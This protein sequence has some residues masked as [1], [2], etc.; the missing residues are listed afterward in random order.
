M[1]LNFF[2]AVPGIN[3][4][5]IFLLAAALND[6]NIQLGDIEN[7]YLTVP[8]RE[9]ICTRSG[10]AFESDIVKVYIINKALYGLKFSGAEFHSFL[11]ED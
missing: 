4:I 11:A 8:C 9:K 7:S 2:R 3:G 6:L 10:P 5:L 1:L